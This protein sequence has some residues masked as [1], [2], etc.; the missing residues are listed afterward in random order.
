MI[1]FLETVGFSFAIV[2]PLEGWEEGKEE[3][4]VCSDLCH[5]NKQKN[6]KSSACRFSVDEAPCV[7]L[8]NRFSVLEGDPQN[9][10]CFEACG[11]QSKTTCREDK[12][13]EKKDFI[14]WK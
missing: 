13:S 12:K 9:T 2:W 8:T 11:K 4:Q 10:G 14:A 3:L 5:W 6:S 1:K 7:H